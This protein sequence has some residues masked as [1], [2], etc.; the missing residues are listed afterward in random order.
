MLI[1]ETPHSEELLSRLIN[2]KFRSA[3]DYMEGQPAP[4]A[5]AVGYLAEKFGNTGWFV[6]EEP[7]DEWD[8]TLVEAD[9]VARIVYLLTGEYWE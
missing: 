5:S 7:E 8:Y 6:E 2:W 3:K 1:V 4:V 9:L